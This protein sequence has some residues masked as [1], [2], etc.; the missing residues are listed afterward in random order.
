MII[1]GTKISRTV[2]E[3]CK[4]KVE[5]LQKKHPLS[6]PQLAFICVG[7]HPSSLSYIKRKKQKCHEVGISSKDIFLP[8]SVSEE[9][10]VQEIDILNHDL[11]THGILVQLPLPK[12]INPFAIMEAVDPE[13]DVDGFH[14]INMG[15]L[16]LGEKD[17]F[18]PCTPLGIVKL[19]QASK[20]EI[21]GKHI[22]IL[23]RSN[24]VGKPLAALLVQKSLDGNATV[25]VAHSYTK[26]LAEVCKSADILI[27]AIGHAHFVKP[28]MVKKGAIVIDVGINKVTTDDHTR[29]VGDV[30]YEAVSPLCSYISPVPG[31][32]G[33]MTIAM[34]LANNVRS[35]EKKVF[36][37]RKDN[38]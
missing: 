2:E 21:Q 20:I 28:E 30:D 35:F 12:H 4:A 23:G 25:T 29:I 8:E 19:L 26:N 11:E 32:V 31:G 5:N 17:G 16:L 7:N 22:V 33:P 34:L 38:F 15:K 37:L 10:L 9:K 36:T 18:I 27:A 24:I 1:D 6:K 3:E 14:P 13:K